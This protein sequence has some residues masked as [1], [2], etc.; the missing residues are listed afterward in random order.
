MASLSFGVAALLQKL[1]AT[2]KVMTSVWEYLIFQGI[3]TLILGAIGFFIF[4]EQMTREEVP[5]YEW[6]IAVGV[7]LALGAA[8]IFV[9]YRFG[10]D[11]S[12]VQPLVNT[13]TL[14]AVILGL[15]V[16]GEWHDLHTVIDWVKLLI[17]AGA[18]LGGGILISM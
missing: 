7:M 12:R 15:V 13:N 3:A 16:L 17:G 18:I 5:A 4:R 1:A 14:I 9:A 10:G 8:L 11:A 6:A 2:G